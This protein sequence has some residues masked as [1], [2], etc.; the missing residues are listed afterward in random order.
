MEDFIASPVTCYTAYDCEIH[1]SKDSKLGKLVGSTLYIKVGSKSRTCSHGNETQE[2]ICYQYQE[3]AG[4][5]CS[6]C[7]YTY[8]VAKTAIGEIES[9]NS[10]RL[11]NTE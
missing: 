1:C 3:R 2:D 10:Y 8:T 5:A 9:A 11:T 6:L 7:D 4:Y